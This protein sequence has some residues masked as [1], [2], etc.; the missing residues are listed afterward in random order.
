MFILAAGV[1]LF[2]ALSGFLANFFLTPARVDGGGDGTSTLNDPIR[3][4]SE[5][6]ARFS[7]EF[8]AIRD[9][10]AA[11]TDDGRPSANADTDTE[12]G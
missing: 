1:S 8:A 12:V 9:A 5:L 6:E 3:M 10:M 11:C 7:A 2:G 4:L